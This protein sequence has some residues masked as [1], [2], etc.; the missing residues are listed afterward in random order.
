MGGK[1]WG[2]EGC[3][4][5]WQCLILIAF[6]NCIPEKKTDKTLLNHE[7]IHSFFHLVVNKF[8]L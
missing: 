5:I 8:G 1:S 2:G 7:L 4:G 6:Q 3:G